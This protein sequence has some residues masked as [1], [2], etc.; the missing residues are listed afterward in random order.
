MS[1]MLFKCKFICIMIEKICRKILKLWIIRFAYVYLRYIILDLIFKTKTF[2]NQSDKDIKNLGIFKS[3]TVIRHNLEFSKRKNIL[4]NYSFNIS[5]FLGLRSNRLILPILQLPHLNIGKSKILC[6]GPRTEGE[7]YN[8]FTHGFKLKN[9]EAIDLISY[10]NKIKLCDA[11]NLFYKNNTF[12]IILC[13]YTLTYSINRKKM[14]KEIIRCSKNNSIVAVAISSHKENN[15]VNYNYGDKNIKTSIDL[16]LLFKK[17]IKKI[18]FQNFT[19]DFSQKEK[20]HHYFLIF[21][22]KK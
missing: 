8:L 7:I 13:S 16:H 21:S 12:D 6:I 20:S 1:F 9:I 22:V 17:Y 19:S 14:I 2:Y 3:G 4:T 18:Y 5:E 11:H 15:R 10:S